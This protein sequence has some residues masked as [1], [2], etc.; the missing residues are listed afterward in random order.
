MIFNSAIKT[1]TK[2]FFNTQT[3]I[4]RFPNRN[5]IF[6]SLRLSSSLSSPSMFSSFFNNSGTKLAKQ[7]RTNKRGIFRNGLLVYWRLFSHPTHVLF[8]SGNLI[9]IASFSS[10]RTQIR[11]YSPNEEFESLPAQSNENENSITSEPNSSKDI[12]NVLN[13]KIGFLENM[14]EETSDFLPQEQKSFENRQSVVMK[15]E[16]F[17]LIYEYYLYTQ[18]LNEATNDKDI[19]K[20]ADLSAVSMY[21]T[22]KDQRALR[23][24]RIDF[25]K[26]I[27]KLVYKM[28]MNF[29]NS[30]LNGEGFQTE[31]LTSNKKFSLYP[32]HLKTLCNMIFQTRLSKLEDFIQLYSSIEEI[33][34]RQLLGRWFY[35]NYYN[36]PMSFDPHRT[37]RSHEKFFQK[38][39][40][41]SDDSQELFERYLNILKDSKKCCFYFMQSKKYTVSFSTLLIILEKCM[42]FKVNN[43]TIIRLLQCVRNNSDCVNKH[44]LGE[45]DKPE[46]DKIYVNLSDFLG[47]EKPFK[48]KRST[49]ELLHPD[50]EAPKK[51]ESFYDLRNPKRKFIVETIS[52]N[53]EFL[54]LVAQLSKTGNA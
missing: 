13:R 34:L 20:K 19:L 40:V 49:K 21:K 46:E 7:C 1:F 32:T 42:S 11:N 26:Q 25:E 35:D 17:E 4:R 24:Q 15:Y 8:L 36:L 50:N 14:T 53:K 12:E 16:L 22:W 44:M 54:R 9:A 30:N 51:S 23:K 48:E 47:I 28:N 3:C 6:H 33:K 39:L 37:V 2:R 52:K 43:D 38:L 27:E 31:T 45:A 10:A 5:K 18:C 41:D 29:G